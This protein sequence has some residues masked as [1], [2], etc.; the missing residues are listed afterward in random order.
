MVA[1]HFKGKQFIQNYHLAVKY[2]QL[3]PEEDKSLTDKISLYDNLILHGDN[4]K[5]LKALLPTYAGRIL[6][7]PYHDF[8]QCGC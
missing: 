6:T 2:H 4:L 8:S 3:I 1:I 5:A 7:F